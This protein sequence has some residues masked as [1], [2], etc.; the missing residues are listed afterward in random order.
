M[1][2]KAH[3]RSS[4]Q[5]YSFHVKRQGPS[6]AYTCGV[7]GGGCVCFCL[8]VFVVVVFLFCFVFVFKNLAL[9]QQDT[10]INIKHK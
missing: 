10:L 9:R 1:Y 5:L 3:E 2:L 6:L 7:G 8:F 4:S